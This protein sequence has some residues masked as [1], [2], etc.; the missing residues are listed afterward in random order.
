[1]NENI[2]FSCFHFLSQVSCNWPTV[3]EIKLIS[4]HSPASVY[5]KSEVNWVTI[6]PVN[7]PIIS[8][9]LNG[10]NEANTA[11]NKFISDELTNMYLHQISSNQS[12]H[13]VSSGLVS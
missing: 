3:A 8:W 7:G 5:T 13:H 2:N 1:M 11:P 9:P 4:E 10:L 6:F 12:I